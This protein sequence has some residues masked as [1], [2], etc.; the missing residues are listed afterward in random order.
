MTNSSDRVCAFPGPVQSLHQVVETA[1]VA[2]IT[3]VALDA[4]DVLRAMWEPLSAEAV[5]VALDGDDPMT[6]ALVDV[7]RP[8]RLL[9][10]SSVSQGV[11]LAAVMV[12]PIVDE[13]PELSRNA[14]ASWLADALRDVAQGAGQHGEWTELSFHASRAWV[15]P[16]D[17][18]PGE[19]ELRLRHEAGTVVAPIE[20]T[21]SGSWLSGP[22]DP[23]FDQPPLDVRITHEMG[24]VT[25]KLT[26]NYGYWV[27]AGEPAA[28]RYDEVVGQ[29]RGMGWQ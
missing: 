22:R 27:D 28:A 4:I 26:R 29:L 21:A 11:L 9:V 10:R 15:G 3:R 25:I 14:L 8:H 5:L 19:E 13:V 2:T 23:A 1:D 18:R 20:R 17:W 16:G 12:D 7:A 24:L 6:A